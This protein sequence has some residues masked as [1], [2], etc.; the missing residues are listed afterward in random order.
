LQSLLPLLWKTPVIPLSAR[1]KELLR[2]Q[3]FVE[4]L[5]ISSPMLSI[6]GIIIFFSIFMLLNGLLRIESGIV[7]VSV[8][9]FFVLIIFL[10]NLLF[11]SLLRKKLNME[12]DTFFYGIGFLSNIVSF[13]VSLD[14]LMNLANMP[15]SEKLLLSRL[16]IVSLFASLFYTYAA[17]LKKNEKGSGKITLFLLTITIVLA[18]ALLIKDF[19]FF[20]QYF[21]TL[22]LNYRIFQTVITP[23]I[24]FGLY[25]GYFAVYK[26]LRISLRNAAW[27]SFLTVFIAV[28]G[29]LLMAIFAITKGDFDVQYAPLGVYEEP[30]EIYYAF[31]GVFYFAISFIISYIAGAVCKQLKKNQTMLPEN[32]V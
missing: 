17:A 12:I 25:A 15:G 31:P 8:C 4:M 1:Q 13:A 24:L 16:L 14:V 11:F 7:L 28:F 2:N 3:S 21:E 29:A 19:E 27:A 22:E 18:V 23:P 9:V 32:S 10:P 5:I 30:P 26:T 6:M 20:K